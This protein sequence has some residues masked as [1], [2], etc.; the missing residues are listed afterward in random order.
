MAALAGLEKRIF[1]IDMKQ[2]KIH[3]QLSL[4]QAVALSNVITHAL[5]E[6]A[7]RITPLGARNKRPDSG[8]LEEVHSDLR[9][10]LVNT[11]DYALGE[12]TIAELDE[13]EV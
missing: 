6:S 7:T 12:Q 9:L 13:E 10:A 2:Q 8:L 1:D 4:G 3:L 5:A 11:A